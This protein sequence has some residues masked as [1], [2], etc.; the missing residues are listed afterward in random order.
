MSY[1]KNPKGGCKS[2]T[3][4]ASQSGYGVQELHKLTEGIFEIINKNTGTEQHRHHTVE[5]SMYVLY[6]L[7]D[8]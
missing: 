1:L 7:Y 4:V 2:A 5:V 3:V 8:G 6:I